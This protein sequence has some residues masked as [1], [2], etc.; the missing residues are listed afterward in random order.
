M[1]ELR[2]NPFPDISQGTTVSLTTDTHIGEFPFVTEFTKRVGE[3]LDS[4][5]AYTHGY[6]HA[7]DAMHWSTPGAPEDA[8]TAAWY[9]ARR[10]NT[11]K[12]LVAVAGNHDLASY[13]VPKPWRTDIEWATAVSPGSPVQDMGDMRVIGVSP[14]DWK[15][16]PETG[17]G[18]MTLSS[19]KLNWLDTQL[20]LAG[21]RPCW[22]VTHSAPEEQYGGTAHVEPIAEFAEIIGSHQNAVGVLSGH[23]HALY[24]VRPNHCRVTEMGGRRV[25]TVNGPAAGGRM[26]GVPF[27]DHQYKSP[28]VSMF[29]TYDDGKLTARWRSH[30]DRKWDFGLGVRAIELNL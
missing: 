12:P 4:L 8:A 7:G 23:L 22:V 20:S 27:A 21:S 18:Q 19:A 16:D 30:L 6:I 15:A 3:D 10:T 14:D 28:A 17:W 29:L 24:T 13:V 2:H 25:F 26:N 1:L 9:A 11:G 5:K